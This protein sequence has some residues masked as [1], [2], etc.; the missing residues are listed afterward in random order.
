[1]G[2]VLF[3]AFVFVLINLFVDVLYALLDPRVA[4]GK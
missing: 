3:S 4:V 2:A 1:L